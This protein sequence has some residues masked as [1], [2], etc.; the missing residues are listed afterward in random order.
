MITVKSFVAQLI[1]K[2]GILY[3]YEMGLLPCRPLSRHEYTYTC[4]SLS[5][6]LSL[7]V[8]FARGFEIVFS[9]KRRAA[10]S[11]AAEN[12]IFNT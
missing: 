8:V 2:C 11:M 3:N 7:G 9:Q 12:I 1:T 10:C 5:I 4:I 6:H